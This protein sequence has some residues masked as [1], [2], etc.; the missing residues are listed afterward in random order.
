MLSDSP[1]SNDEQSEVLG[2]EGADALLADDTTEAR[3]LHR[4][5][6][7]LGDCRNVALK[8]WFRLGLFID[9]VATEFARSARVDPDPDRG[10]VPCVVVTAAAAAASS[11]VAS[12]SA[13]ARS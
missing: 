2:D 5:D 3:E 12:I 8:T 9:L 13:A 10:R 1:P 4:D 6:A 11:S 7:R